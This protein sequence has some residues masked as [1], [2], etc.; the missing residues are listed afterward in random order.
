MHIV[1]NIGIY[2]HLK[3]VTFN[4]RLTEYNITQQ[5]GYQKYPYFEFE[6]IESRFF[7]KSDISQKIIFIFTQNFFLLLSYRCQ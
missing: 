2:L 7:Y 1:F 5:H 6:I 3:L 4:I